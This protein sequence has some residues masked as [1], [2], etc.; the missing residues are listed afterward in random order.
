MFEAPPHSAP[1]ARPKYPKRVSPCSPANLFFLHAASES[2]KGQDDIKEGNEGG[3]LQPVRQP[4]RAE[5]R[6]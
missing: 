3:A 4:A 5:L 2:L 6:D 1:P